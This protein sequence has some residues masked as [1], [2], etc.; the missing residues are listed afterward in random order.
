MSLRPKILMSTDK[1]SIRI[2][3]DGLF[4]VDLESYEIVYKNKDKDNFL[5]NLIERKTVFPVEITW[6]GDDHIDVGVVDDDLNYNFT[7]TTIDNLEKV[8]RAIL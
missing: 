2:D 3:D 6:L 8:L 7:T 1:Y 4:I 5:D